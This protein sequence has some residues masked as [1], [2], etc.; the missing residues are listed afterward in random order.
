MFLRALGSLCVGT[1]VAASASAGTHMVMETSRLSDGEVLERTVLHVDGSRLRVD[2]DGGKSSVVYL[3]DRQRVWLLDHGDRSYV[4]VDQK[5]TE[6]LARKLG[7][8]NQELRNRIEGLPAEQRAAAERLLNKTLGPGN[9]GSAPRVVVVPN[10]EDEVI[11]GRPCRSFDILRDGERVADVCRAGF[12]EAGVSAET[13]GALRDLAG[14]LRNSIASLAP[15][16]VRSQGLDALDS[17]D[18][19]EGVP[20]RVRSY[21]NGKPVRQSRVTELASRDFPASDFTVPGDYQKQPGLNI[22][23]HIGPP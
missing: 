18:R 14:F 6:S 23:D 2:T 8:L 17:F 11:E 7:H 16:S 4:E 12:A 20:L 1:L 3:A 19:I 21:K 13:L 10:G 9:E 22:R 5:T 15:E